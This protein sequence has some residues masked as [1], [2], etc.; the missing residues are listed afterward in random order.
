M[1]YKVDELESNELVYPSEAQFHFEEVRY[2]QWDV[3]GVTKG[4]HWYAK[5]G[6]MDVKD[7]DGNMKWN[8]KEEAEAA[9]RWFC[10]E[11]N[12]KV[13]FEKKQINE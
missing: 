4:Q 9:A 2:M 7:K 1:Y 13:Y 3:H 11:L 6:N 12:H 10:M 8:T 5:I